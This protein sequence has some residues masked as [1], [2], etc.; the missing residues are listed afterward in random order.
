MALRLWVLA[1][2]RAAV[3]DLEISCCDRLDDPGAQRRPAHPEPVADTFQGAVLTRLDGTVSP[4]G[5]SSDLRIALGAYEAHL[6]LTQPAPTAASGTGAR[7]IIDLE[8]GE[9][10]AR[11]GMALRVLKMLG[12]RHMH[13]CA[14]RCSC[15]S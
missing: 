8:G 6:G 7:F 3:P 4:S 14:P 12:A 5:M 13:V 1:D 10:T 9:P 2:G 15:S 11:L